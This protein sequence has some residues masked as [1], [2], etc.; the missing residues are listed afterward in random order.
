M[1]LR[2][3]LLLALP[4]LAIAADPAPWRPFSADS[5]WNQR[6]SAEAASDRHSQVL[7][8]D[9]ASRGPWLVNM[10]DWSIPV[11]FVDAAR[12]PGQDVGDSR[13][14]VYGAGFEFPRAIP[15]PDGAIASPPVGEHSDNHLCIIDRERGIEWGMWAARQDANGRWFTG[16]GAVTDL[17][18]TGVAPP[19]YISPREYDSHGARASGFPLVAG[20]IFVD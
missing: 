16:L 13:P 19:W 17:N 4:V 2:C 6:I 9:L 10:K 14:G 5:P 18:G 11:Y 15:I 20:L 12:T 7:I 3:L 1:S 8:D